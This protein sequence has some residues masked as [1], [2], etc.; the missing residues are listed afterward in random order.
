MRTKGAI[1]CSDLIECHHHNK[2]SV[3]TQNSQPTSKE[4]YNKWQTKRTKRH[5]KGYSFGCTPCALCNRTIVIIIIINRTFRFSHKIINSKERISYV[6]CNH[7]QPKNDSSHQR[8]RNLREDDRRHISFSVTQAETHQRILFHDSIW[9]QTNGWCFFKFIYW[10]WVQFV[11]FIAFVYLILFS[12]SSVYYS[13]PCGTRRWNSSSRACTIRVLVRLCASSDALMLTKSDIY[14]RYNIMYAREDVLEMTRRTANFIFSFYA[15]PVLSSCSAARCFVRSNTCVLLLCKLTD[16]H[17][18][19][20][21]KIRCRY[22]VG[23]A[24]RK[25]NICRMNASSIYSI[26]IDKMRGAENYYFAANVERFLFTC[27]VFACD[28]RC[29]LSIVFIWIFIIDQIYRR[30]WQWDRSGL[31]LGLDGYDFTQRMWQFRLDTNTTEEV[32]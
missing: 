26:L 32:N 17:T 21:M 24:I 8:Y 31:V 25:C 5:R 15:G 19:I 1:N 6:N 16:S 28:F 29:Q 22:N 10:K 2:R 30:K 9:R 13:C 20:A 27:L 4:C 12:L 11:C 7:T 23:A 3:F 18:D 14:A